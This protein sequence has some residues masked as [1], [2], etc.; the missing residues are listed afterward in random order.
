MASVAIKSSKGCR[1]RAAGRTRTGITSRS[2]EAQRCNVSRTGADSRLHRELGSEERQ[3][4]TS[5]EVPLVGSVVLTCVKRGPERDRE[6]DILDFL[7][8]TH[9]TDSLNIV[10][11]DSPPN[12]PNPR[13]SSPPP[14]R[15]L[16]QGAPDAT[17]STGRIRP[18]GPGFQMTT[19][20]QL[21][22][23]NPVMGGRPGGRPTAQHLIEP[24]P[25]VPNL[26]VGNASAAT[27]G[28]GKPAPELAAT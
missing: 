25:G 10:P 20:R 28:D 21:L 8:T 23:P 13:F 3:R 18:Q 9:S 27:T 19:P 1:E 4:E 5:K 6:A 17:F 11:S 16:F 15:M 14:K 22:A 12:E 2:W 7:G 26:L 24:A